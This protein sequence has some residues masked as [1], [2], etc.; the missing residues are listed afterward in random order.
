MVP[1]VVG[2]GNDQSWPNGHAL[3]S[4][5]DKSSVGVV[6][7][8]AHL[9][10]RPLKDGKTHSGSPFRQLLEEGL[11]GDHFVEFAAQ[12]NQCSAIHAQYVLDQGG[13]I[14]W[15]SSLRV[16]L[17]IGSSHLVRRRDQLPN[18]L[19]RC[20]IHLAK[21]SS[22][23]LTLILSSEAIVRYHSI[24]HGLT[25]SGS[26]RCSHD[27]IDLS[28]GIGYVFHRRQPSKCILHLHRPF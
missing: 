21:I 8:D 3:L 11:R 7:I 14:M 19:K 18:L 22:S 28:R 26:E 10:V 6:N 16:N 20:W 2:G 17:E 5:Y 4:R 15:L 23:L 1:F 12:G 25:S 27:W 9:D 13:K 24:H